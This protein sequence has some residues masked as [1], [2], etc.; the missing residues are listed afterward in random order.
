MMCW[1]KISW[2]EVGATFENE[3]PIIYQTSCGWNCAKHGFS[4]SYDYFFV[5][6]VI[7]LLSKVIS[8]DQELD[9]KIKVRLKDQKLYQE[10]KNK[11]KK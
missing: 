8:T 1:H 9:Q 4:S 3:I 11:V 5:E 10:I 7:N 2:G 6:D